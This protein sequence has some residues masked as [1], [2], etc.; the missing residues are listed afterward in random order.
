MLIASDRILTAS[1]NAISEEVTLAESLLR[2]CFLKSRYSLSRECMR[3]GFPLASVTSAFSPLSMARWAMG[4]RFVNRC[5]VILSGNKSIRWAVRIGAESRMLITSASDSWILY[6]SIVSMSFTPCTSN[7]A[8]R[9]R[10]PALTPLPP[11]PRS[12]RGAGGAA[13]YGPVI[14]SVE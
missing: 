10:T 6:L 12:R 5:T 14:G 13:P 4:I 7:T 1:S 9:S 2:A 3:A 8:K 11:E